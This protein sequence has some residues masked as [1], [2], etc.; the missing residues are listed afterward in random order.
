[1]LRPRPEKQ[2]SPVVTLSACPA[3]SL[4]A[5]KA[6]RVTYERSGCLAFAAVVSLPNC[7]TDPI[8]R[9]RFAQDRVFHLSR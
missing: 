5:N 7:A 6:L 2:R 4:R 8:A 9:C 3:R 1:M